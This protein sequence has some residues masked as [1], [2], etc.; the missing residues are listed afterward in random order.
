MFLAQK[1]SQRVSSAANPHLNLKEGGGL[2]NDDRL[3]KEVHNLLFQFTNDTMHKNASVTLV[4]Q[5]LT[6][7]QNGLVTLN[8]VLLR[9]KSPVYNAC[10]LKIRTYKNE[11][12]RS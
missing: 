9:Y 2:F 1:G 3:P 7:L 6:Y 10:P 5:F 12:E 4:L 8:E 11:K